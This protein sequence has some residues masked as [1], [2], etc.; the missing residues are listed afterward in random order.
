MMPKAQSGARGQDGAVREMVYLPG[1][2]RYEQSRD[3]PAGAE[4]LTISGTHVRDHI[5]P[6]ANR[7]PS[8]LPAPRQPDSRRDLSAQFQAGILH[9]VHRPEQ[10]GKEHPRRVLTVMLMER[11]R[12]VTVLDGDVV[13]T[14]LSKGLGFKPGIATPTFC[15]SDLSRARS[16]ATV[17]WICA[18]ISPYRA[19]RN[20]VRAMMGEGSFAEVFVDTPLAGLRAAR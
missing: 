14:H 2:E 12:Q 9:L 16:S 20:Q 10:F 15:A 17:A 18:A 11:G 13:R 6:K 5:S 4:V 8:G 3:V 19:T 7:S 1:E